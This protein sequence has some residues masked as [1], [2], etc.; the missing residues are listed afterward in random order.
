MEDVN[1][2]LLEPIGGHH[3]TNACKDKNMYELKKLI[4]GLG[5]KSAHCICLYGYQHIGLPYT[6]SFIIDSLM[7]E[8][9][10]EMIN[11]Q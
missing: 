5:S 9:V 2:T 4:F 11:K 10:F 6:F 1:E 7:R 3:L 8:I